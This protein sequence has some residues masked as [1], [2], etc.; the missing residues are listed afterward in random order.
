[1]CSTFENLNI[2]H[3]PQVFTAKLAHFTNTN[4][5]AYNPIYEEIVAKRRVTFADGI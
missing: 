2:L 1:M 4:L 5:A 3:H